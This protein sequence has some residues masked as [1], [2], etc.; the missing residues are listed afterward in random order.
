MSDISR[1]HRLENGSL[2]GVDLSAN[3]LVTL[4]IKV[5]GS[6]SNTELT[7]TILDS[8][9]SMQSSLSGT[10]ASAALGDTNTY[11]NF[12]P[13]AATIKGALSGI[14]TALGG[15]QAAGS[16]ITALTGD[17]TASGPGSAS[18]T[19]SNSAVTNAKMA[20]M[21]AHTFKGNNTGSAAAPSDLTAT[22]LTAELNSFVG[23]TGSGGTKGLVPAPAAGD[24]AASKFLK[25]DGTWAT[26]PTTGFA[27]TALSNLSSVAINTDLLPGIDSTINLGSTSKKYSQTW[28]NQYYGAGGAHYMELHSGVKSGIFDTALTTG[29]II[30]FDAKTFYDN[31]AINSSV[32]ADFANRYLK[33]S[34]GNGSTV[35]VEWEGGRLNDHNGLG[36]ISVDWEG[37]I[38]RPQDQTNALDW[39]NRNLVDAT[40]NQSL[41]WLY[42][43]LR[44]TT[45]TSVL[46]WSGTAIVVSKAIEPNANGTLDLGSA[47]NNF[48]DVRAHGLRSNLGLAIEANNGQIGIAAV[49]TG[50]GSAPIMLSADSDIT[51][52]AGANDGTSHPASNI[53]LTA[54][55][56]GAIV[57]HSKILPNVDNTL[58]IGSSAAGFANVYANIIKNSGTAA[59]QVNAT[60]NA[61][62]SV[63]SADGPLELVAGGGSGLGSITINAGAAGVGSEIITLQAAAEVFVNATQLNMNS[64]KIIN[65]ADPTSA[66]H[67]ATKNYVDSVAQGLKPK[68]AVRAATT[69]NGTLA[70]SFANGSVIDSVTLVT[71]DRIL[72]KNQSTASQNGIYTVNATGAPT[73]AVDFDSLTPID[74]INGAY[75]FISEGGQAGQGWVVTAPTVT[76][77]GTSAI[78]FVYFNSVAGII[79]GDMISLTGSTV[80]VDLATV[81]GLEST[82]PGNVA[83]QLRVKLEASNPSLQINGSNELGA[84]LNAAGAIVTGAS[85]LAVQL[86]SSNPSLQIS[87]NQL[88]VKLN[89]S[90]AITSG[91][92]G[93]SANV[94]NSTIEIATNALQVKNAGITLAKLASNSVDEN[95]IVSTALSST[96]A[97]VG[98]SGTKLSVNVDNSTIEIATNALQ[99]KDLGVTTAKLAATSVTATKLGSD[100]AGAGLSGGNGSALTTAYAPMVRKPVTNG[101][102]M[103]ANTAYFVR[104]GNPAFTSPYAPSGTEQADRVY[105]CE[106]DTSGGDKFW[107]IGIA[108]ATAL[109][110]AGGTVNL[111]S[112]GTY[113]Q[114]A[115]DTAFSSGDVGKPLWIATAGQGSMSTTSPT[116]AGYAVFK[117]GIVETT[118]SIWVD[119]QMMGVN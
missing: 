68:A 97:L 95:K 2:R 28:S 61:G 11:S 73:R 24:A 104:W 96:G 79:G 56:T 58:D 59:L 82:N 86:E 112:L 106:S 98:G 27:N 20:N 15:K 102:D 114:L 46:D 53:N 62:L 80:S 4:S 43:Q 35:T 94:D 55:T 84:K 26:V 33:N 1:L 40:G 16:Y 22:Q 118:T 17:V 92:S 50:T 83:G 113:L 10:G 76:S 89:G 110:S 7:K 100:V 32:S 91:A 37:R 41:A 34:A 45:S 78:N 109:T 31:T 39:G 23:D 14:D 21:A 74:E 64:T 6:V 30:D 51:L 5:G 38:L 101:F 119:R 108:Y 111:I 42:R 57:A 93:I 8:L 67:A 47:T 66:Q 63:Y 75:T 18:A 81:S 99:I 72:I 71:G 90:G 70:S 52:T 116:T 48:L 88:G 87:S 85:G 115:N 54:G 9:I 107:G 65:L 77:I 13:T 25:A 105:P 69:V 44:D 117:V 3:T 19:I 29:A 36:S 49:D 12:T 60:A 103:A